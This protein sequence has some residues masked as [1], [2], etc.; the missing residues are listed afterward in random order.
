LDTRAGILMTGGTLAGYISTLS[1]FYKE[2]LRKI[3]ELRAYLSDGN[4]TLYGIYIHAL[5]STLASIGSNEMSKAAEALELAAQR[6]NLDFILINNNQFLGG[7]QTLLHNINAAISFKSEPVD[8][9]VLKPDLIRLKTAMT[10]YDIN[11]INEI[12]G[13]LQR[14]SQTAGA[15]D[16]VDQ[17]LQYKLTGGY[18]EA[19]VFIDEIL[20][21]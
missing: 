21:M 18:D 14:F 9:E 2:S 19:V 13:K 1:I 3:E 11:A 17:I 15:G 6:N 4:L 10:D 16:I 12:A 20:T 8:L 5:K 7:L